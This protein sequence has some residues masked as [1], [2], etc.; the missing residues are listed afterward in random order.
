VR[1][2]E[3]PFITSFFRFVQEEQIGVTGLF[4]LK[5]HPNLNIL[6]ASTAESPMACFLQR[7]A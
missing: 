4:P 2:E 3:V 7:P 5:E 6:M 1:I